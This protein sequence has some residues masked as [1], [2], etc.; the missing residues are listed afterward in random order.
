LIIERN[1]AAF[2]VKRSRVHSNSKMQVAESMP[3]F[4]IVI[5]T[6][7]RCDLLKYAIQ[8]VLQQDCNDYELIVSD[9]D[10]SDNTQS[11]VLQLQNPKVR[12]ANTGRHLRSAD[13]WNFAYSQAGGE[14]ILIL[15]DDDYLLPSVLRQVK[16]VIEKTSSLIVAWKEIF[17]F[18]GDCDHSTFRDAIVTRYY[19]NK[20]IKVSTSE[21]LKIYFNLEDWQNRKTDNTRHPSCICISRSITNEIV[22]KYG[23]F[24][25][26]PFS[27]TTSIPRALSYTDYLYVIDKPL[28]VI[29][30]D[31]RSMTNKFTTDPNAAFNEHTTELTLVPFKGKYN[32]NLYA[33]SLLRVKYGDPE[34]FK[35]YELN[36]EVYSNLYYQSMLEASRLGFDIKND[37]TDFNRKIIYMP[38]DVQTRIQKKIYGGRIRKC[39][40]HSPMYNIGF[41]RIMMIKTYEILMKIKYVSVLKFRLRNDLPERPKLNGKEF[42]VYDIASCAGSLQKIAR[43]LK[44]NTEAWDYQTDPT[45]RE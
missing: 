5:P 18:Y 41:I 34:R 15:G 27:D 19:T 6:R 4:S 37:V 8:S 30:R 12:Y 28:V 14:Y 9:N 38:Q 44:Q 29:G 10:S 36:M 33:E 42:G 39:L 23:A 40:R 22:R 31:P 1:K 45:W 2:L 7:N 26:A 32:F 17:Y 43:K 20:I 11:M 21:L 3:L 24:C 25:Q 35:D 13:S 16:T